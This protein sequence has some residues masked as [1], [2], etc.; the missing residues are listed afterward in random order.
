[1]EEEGSEGVTR[2]RW[3]AECVSE[4]RRVCLCTWKGGIKRTV[5]AAS[6]YPR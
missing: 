4:W 3:R 5:I 1:M 2:G 6:H